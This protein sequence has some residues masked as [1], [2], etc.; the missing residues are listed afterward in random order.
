MSEGTAVVNCN[1]I[2]NAHCFCYQTTAGRKICCKCG[3]MIPTTVVHF[4]PDTEQTGD[5]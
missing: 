2:G 3:H 4:V 1:R 5:V